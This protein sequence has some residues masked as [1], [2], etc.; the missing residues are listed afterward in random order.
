MNDL[1]KVGPSSNIPRK[2][3]Y[4]VGVKNITTTGS[5]TSVTTLPN[6]ATDL[7]LGLEKCSSLLTQRA[8]VVMSLSPETG[9]HTN[10]LTEMNL[11]ERRR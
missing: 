7:G 6:V 3:R 4:P 11:A 2:Y 1:C 9:A 8:F 10:V 5:G